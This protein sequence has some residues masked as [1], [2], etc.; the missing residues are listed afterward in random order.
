MNMDEFYMVYGSNNEVMNMT[1]Q[2]L[3]EKITSVLG[4]IE[5]INN[6]DLQAYWSNLEDLEL[7]NSS[8][9]EKTLEMTYSSCQ[10]PTNPLIRVTFY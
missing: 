1:F 10:K 9:W 7:V 6:N 5:T 2:E 3:K 4:E 8:N